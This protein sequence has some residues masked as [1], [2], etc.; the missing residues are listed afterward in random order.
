MDFGLIEGEHQSANRTYH[1]LWKNFSV[2]SKNTQKKELNIIRQDNNANLPCRYKLAKQELKS[3][4][5]MP[6]KR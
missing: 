4:R 6:I 2:K 3:D 1:V 5:V